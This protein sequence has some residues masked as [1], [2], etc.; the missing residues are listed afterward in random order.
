[1]IEAPILILGLVAALFLAFV[2]LAR[3]SMPYVFCNAT[4]S[5]W[6]ARFLPESKLAELAGAPSAEAVLSALEESEY[7]EQIA[8]LRRSAPVDPLEFERALREN[9]NARYRELLGMLPK[10]R[11][12]T[13][14]RILSRIDVWNLKA[15][16]SMIHSGVTPGDRARELMPSPTMSRERLEMLASARTLE[17]LL[18]YLRGSEYHH[19]ISGAMEAYRREGLRALL[20][21]LDRHYWSSL[22]SDVL[23]R[24]DQRKVMRE[25]IG[26]E[27]DSLNAR[28]ILRLKQER[29]P[30]EE[31]SACI[32]RPSHELNEEMLRAMVMAEDL[33][34]AINMIHI[35]TVGRVLSEVSG[36]IGEKGAT[37]AEAAL[38]RGRIRLFRW[39][40]M[41]RFFTVAPAISYIAQK[42]HELKKLRTIYRLKFDGAEPGAVRRTLEGM[43]VGA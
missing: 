19:V 32:V 30:P 29:A 9:A 26:Y 7:R 2:L 25:M 31:I 28:L 4:L 21:A 5:A 23:G 20:L 16:I 37:A 14:A 36:E 39:L 10:G 42:E 33:A 12:A 41:T 27:L 34:S 13:V 22:W 15:I 6:E 17:E 3:R 8:E 24:R 40:A 38:E 35:T 18:E 1:M 11:R 43:M